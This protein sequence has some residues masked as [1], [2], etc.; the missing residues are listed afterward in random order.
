MKNH[1]ST[2]NLS[3]LGIIATAIFSSAVVFVLWYSWEWTD[4]RKVISQEI[5]TELFENLDDTQ[6]THSSPT[7]NT[8]PLELKIPNPNLLPVHGIEQSILLERDHYNSIHK[9]GG[10]TSLE[11]I[12]NTSTQVVPTSLVEKHIQQLQVIYSY[13]KINLI[14]LVKDSPDRVNSLNTMEKNLNESIQRLEKSISELE[15]EISRLKIEY[16]SHEDQKNAATKAY[17]AALTNFDGKT[18]EIQLE[19]IIKKEQTAAEYY[20]RFKSLERIR[21]IYISFRTPLNKKLSILVANRAAL[22]KGVSVVSIS[23]MQE[24]LIL[25]ESEWRNMLR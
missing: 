3:L 21:S 1:F 2:K 9:L 17:N 8:L 20:S 19:I 25:T 18:M 6:S 4:A 7:N 24:D 11:K 10:T 13:L 15:S 12:I 23:G 14:D 16:T 5:S 22:L